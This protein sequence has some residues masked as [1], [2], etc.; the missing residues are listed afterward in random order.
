MTGKESAQLEVIDRRSE[1][2][3][4]PRP[5]NEDASPEESSHFEVRQQ[6]TFFHICRY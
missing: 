6:G 1:D 2:T 4:N 3:S 5:P